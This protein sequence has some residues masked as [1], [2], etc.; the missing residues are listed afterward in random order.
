MRILE[1]TYKYLTLSLELNFYAASLITLVNLLKGL[2]H[3]QSDLNLAVN[4][5]SGAGNRNVRRYCD[6]FSWRLMF[7]NKYI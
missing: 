6:F 2:I 1:L 3:N 4:S 7:Q 5:R